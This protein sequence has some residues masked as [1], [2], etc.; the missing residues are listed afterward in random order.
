MLKYVVKRI[1]SIIPITLAV[2]LIIFIMLYP[3]PGSRLSQLPLY[4]NGDALDRVFAYFDAGKNLLTM[5]ARYCYNALIH[6]DFGTSGVSRLKVSGEL[7]VR[8]ANTL[9]LTAYGA[10]L[11]VIFGI[12]AGIYAATRK[13]SAAD[14]LINISALFLSSIPS[15]CVALILA[16]VFA[17]RFRVAVLSG[18][19]AR[20]LPILTIGISGIAPVA[21]MTRA[22]ML[23]T[24]EQPY[25][26]AL[27]SKGLTE[28]EVIYS[29]A[30]KNAMIPIVSVSGKLVSQLL[31]GAIVVESFFS[32]QGIGS[33][34]LRSVS[35]RDHYAIL[36]SAAALT[37]VLT[38]VNILTD[39]LYAAITPQIRSK[40]MS[41]SRRWRGAGR[42]AGRS[43]ELGAAPA[44]QSSE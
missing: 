26:T 27:R 34:M 20:L 9:R 13:N 28:W 35:S 6:Q 23:E 7:P 43:V 18:P 29:H 44:R 36:G 4:G 31:C 8:L 1:I 37:V 17:L 14:H 11:T 42:S 15:Y 12:P 3:L 32:K 39:T 40:L 21:R 19:Y 10:G 25:I 22:S 5:Y 30:L 24:L 33:Y 16:L 38:T 41:R 2:T